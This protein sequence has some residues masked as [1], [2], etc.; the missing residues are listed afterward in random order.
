MKK[1]D[2]PEQCIAGKVNNYKYQFR[3]LKQACFHYRIA[4]G[5]L[6]ILLL[7]ALLVE[8]LTV[9]IFRIDLSLFEH[10]DPE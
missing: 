2:N 10:T 5:L 4:F 9:R 8:L 1:V 6:L 3:L 7:P